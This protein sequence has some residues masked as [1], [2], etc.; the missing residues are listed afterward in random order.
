MIEPVHNSETSEARATTRLPVRVSYFALSMLVITVAV[1]AAYMLLNIH[2][3]Q[4]RDAAATINMAGRQRMLSQQIALMVTELRDGNAAVRERILQAADLMERSH[5][6]LTKGDGGGAMAVF[7]RRS[8]AT[9]SKR[10]MLP[11]PKSGHSSRRRAGPQTAQ[12]QSCRRISPARPSHRFSRGWTMGSR[13]SRK[14]PIPAS[15]R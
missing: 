8:S 6:A 3:Q 10:R 11:T 12:R 15:N 1:A 2:I 7:S 14:K 4:E 13:C 5:L 9:F